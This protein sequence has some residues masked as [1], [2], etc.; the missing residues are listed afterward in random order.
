M[1][2]IGHDQKMILLGGYCGQLEKG[3]KS[4]CGHISEGQGLF[5]LLRRSTDNDDK[6][7]RKRRQL[8]LLFVSYA[9]IFSQILIP[10]SFF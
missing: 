6:E 7:M 2:D 8:A 4:V 3:G 9:E 10:S 1:Y 5:P